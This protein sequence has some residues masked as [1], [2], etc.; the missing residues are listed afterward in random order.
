M[1]KKSIVWI[2]CPV[3]LVLV[4]LFVG[5][6]FH[7]N[8][9]VI[10]GDDANFPKS[11]A[12]IMDGNGRWAKK[13]HLPVGEGHRKGMEALER[14]LDHA[15]KIGVKSLTIYAFSLENWQ[16]PKN[17][18]DYIMTLVSSYLDKNV[19]TLMENNVK[20]RVIGN[21]DMVSPEMRSR[22][23]TAEK[24]TASNSKFFLNIAFSYGGKN[25]IIDASRN[26]AL[27]VKNGKLD[28]EEI[29]E[30]VF[31]RY[32]YNPEIIYPDIVIRTGGNLRISNFLLWEI[33]Y[34][35][36]Y[37]TDT[38]WPDFNEK[39]FDIAIEDFMKRK[40]TYGKRHN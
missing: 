23:L 28:A 29:N 17:E 18:V 21:L 36:L 10:S 14:I 16:R 37:F 39:A 25:E 3:V 6:L 2:L 24:K 38:L 15:R 27:D 12:I 9:S 26:I 33:S 22:M 5:K 11:I 35:E 31:K 7:K 30:T 32:L 20:L 1:P 4:F 8:K 40:R 34:S 13:R 19:D